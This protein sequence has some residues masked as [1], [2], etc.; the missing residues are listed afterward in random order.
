VATVAQG[1][2]DH[3]RPVADA[4]VVPDARAIRAFASLN[5]IEWSRASGDITRA[6]L[7]AL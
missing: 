1:S 5:S 2:D 3:G 7:S 4:R 6:I